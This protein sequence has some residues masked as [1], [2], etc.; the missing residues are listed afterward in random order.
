M[1]CQVPSACGTTTTLHSHHLQTLNSHHQLTRSDFDA[2]LRP[3]FRQ[4]TRASYGHLQNASEELAATYVHPSRTDWLERDCPLCADSATHASPLMFKLGMQLLTCARCS[5]SYSRQVLREDAEQDLYVGSTFQT[6]YRHLKLNPA[7]AELETT[8][9][10]YIMQ[11][12]RRHSIACGTLLDIGAGSGCLL[13]AAREA[14]WKA[15]GIEAN[16]GFVELCWSAGLEVEQGFFPHI[17]LDNTTV[18]VVTMLDVIEHAPDPQA[19]L[20]VVR[21][22]LVDNGL[23]VLQVPNVDSLL[24]RLQGE[25]SSN[26]CIGHWNH[27]NSATLKKLALAAGFEP[28]SIETIISEL[29]LILEFAPAR[30]AETVGQITGSPPGDTKMDTEWL[31]ERGL[32]Y[33]VLGIFRRKALPDA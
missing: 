30:I 32:G 16:P 13:S 27:F 4:A 5:M 2:A 24:V 22:Q 9:C 8:K 15:R 21:S 29:D 33:K 7:Y 20:Q 10:R 18:D 26:F 12:L 19:L 25:A 31:H 3:G 11:Q 14:G 28:L 6:S 23:L 17:R 1:H